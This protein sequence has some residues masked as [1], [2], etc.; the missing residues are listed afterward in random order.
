MDMMGIIFSNI[1]DNNMGELT[2]ERTSASIPFGGR[3]R[4]IDF[5]L[6][7]MANSGIRDIG[8]ITKYNYQSLMDHIG[9]GK[10]WD[11]ARRSGGIKILPPY[12]T[13]YANNI[14]A[15]YR[16]RMEALKSVNYSISRI[17]DEYVIMSDCD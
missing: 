9:S 12:I 11:L 8:I 13:A 16:T 10:D 15:L 4:Q 7:N 1:Y 6:S 5:I 17:K 2:R 3:Y 14:N